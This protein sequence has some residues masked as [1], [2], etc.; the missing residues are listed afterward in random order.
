MS[1]YITHRNTMPPVL[2]GRKEQ[3]LVIEGMTVGVGPDFEAQV[4]T[5]DY[6]WECTDEPFQQ[7]VENGQY[8]LV[9]EEIVLFARLVV[10]WHQERGVTSS[11]SEMTLCPSYLKIIGMGET[12]I[13]LILAQ[14]KD[15]KDDPDHW[16]AALE[17]ITGADPVPEEAY[18][19]TVKIAEAW[20]AWAE[21]NNV[22]WSVR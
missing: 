8:T 3:L 1:I 11:L 15:E 4:R 7:A 12:A 14:M 6:E 19:D 20:F 13:P 21:E 9:Q 16:S 2:S 22:W 10:Q 5:R 17:A 18:G